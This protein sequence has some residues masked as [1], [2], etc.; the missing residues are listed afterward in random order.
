MQTLIPDDFVLESPYATS[1]ITLEDC[2]SHR[3]GM[4]SHHADLGGLSVKEN[5]RKLRYLQMNKEPRTSWQYSN[6][7]YW[8][9][10]HMIEVHSRMSLEKFMKENIWGPLGMTS[11]FLSNKTAREFSEVPENADFAKS[12]MWDTEAKGFKKLPYWNDEGIS[13]AGGMVSN[14]VDYAKWIRSFINQDGPL[15]PEG[16]AAVTSPHMIMPVLS[17]RFTG[18]L[19]YGF[20]WWIS[21]Y[22]GERVLLHPGGLIGFT[23]SMIYLPDKKWGVVGMCN[24]TSETVLD[25]PMWYLVD[26]F[27]GLPL[28]HEPDV[29]VE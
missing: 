1:H 7:L 24:G 27:L 11:T 20:G 3:T 13:G 8:A 29:F 23:A 12:Y 28:E 6:H 16:Y 17:P 4:M 15:S 2:L 5:T 9:V 26:R 10:C 25:I 14:V 18:P 22:H 21:V 19:C